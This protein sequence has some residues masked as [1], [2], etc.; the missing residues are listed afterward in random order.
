MGV[1]EALEPLSLDKY[2]LRSE[3][4]GRER[5][6]TCSSLRLRVSTRERA[7]ASTFITKGTGLQSCL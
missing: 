5:E 3:R 2:Y 7:E 4:G 6:E 1:S